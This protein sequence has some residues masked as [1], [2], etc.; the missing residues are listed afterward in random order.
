MLFRVFI[1]AGLIGLACGCPPDPGFPDAMVR[2]TVA[3]GSITASWSI[4]DRAGVELGGTRSQQCDRAGATKVILT[5]TKLDGGSN[6]FPLGSCASGQATE[7][8]D[9]GTYH[10]SFA[11]LGFENGQNVPITSIER[12]AVAVAADL[13]TPLVPA[14]TFPIDATG[15][16]QL[17]LLADT[18]GNCMGGA[19]ITG[20][21]ISLA[22][23]GGPG[24]TACEPVVFALST[25]GTFDAKS[26][27][28]PSVQGCVDRGVTLTAPRLP[29]GPYLIQVIGKKLSAECWTNNDSFSVPSQGK[30]LVKE[31]KLERKSGCPCDPG[32]P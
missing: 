16:L 23:D 24:D 9:V 1:L 20:L 26:C 8:L 19:G 28:S 14:I 15:G 29:S 31:L 32:C 18:S 10:L 4:T 25:G 6:E 22:H 7:V 21:Q 30:T 2:D 27:S 5:A 17:T 12:S 13:P 11:L 3:Q